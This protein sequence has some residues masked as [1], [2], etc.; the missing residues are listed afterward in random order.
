[1][2]LI[3][4]ITSCGP[5][6]MMTKLALQKMKPDHNYG[7]MDTSYAPDYS[8]NKSWLVSNNLNKEV[9]IFFIHPTS[10]KKNG[11]WNMAIDDTATISRTYRRS[12]R[13]ILSIFDGLGN[14]YA[15]KYRQATFYS[16]IDT[17]ENGEHAIDLARKD[18][19]RSFDYYIKYINQGR[20]FIL[21]SH[22]QGSLISMD[23]L[24]IIYNNT[25]L[26]NQLITAYVVGWPIGLDYLDQH[27][28]IVVCEDSTQTGCIVSWN[29]ETKHAG[30]TLV[31]K[32]SLCINPLNWSQ[33][34]IHISKM[35]NKGAVFFLNE[36]PDTI[37]NYIGVEC[38]NGI[39]RVD[40]VPNK[41]YL[42]GQ[43]A[44]GLLHRFDYGFFYLNVK[45][46]AKLRISEYLKNK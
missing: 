6:G 45:S 10:Y 8:L 42:K 21:A 13:R 32:P 16:F 24:P 44:F 11:Q 2:S 31:N 23:I 1:M 25:K 30:A 15:P 19:L 3:L 18:V 46:N 20:P 37:P 29:T 26:R 43:Y 39:L 28:E 5:H 36:E 34:E 4:Y 40:N 35:E 22:S 41:D 27:P 33:E 38:K 7:K 9:D 14:I 12:I 17:K